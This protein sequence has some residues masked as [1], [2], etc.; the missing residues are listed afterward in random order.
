MFSIICIFAF[1]SNH[2]LAAT[3]QSEYSSA[4]AELLI[5]S[6]KDTS[7]QKRGEG[8]RIVLARIK[9]GEI[10]ISELSPKKVL[11]GPNGK[12]TIL[13]STVEEA[14][15]AI[16]C[17]KAKENVIYAEMDSPVY[18]CETHL[19]DT[20]EYSFHSWAAE[21][22]GYPL[23][24]DMANVEASGSIL[25]AIIDSGVAE[26]RLLRPRLSK[27]GFDYVDN[28]L[29]PT[30]DGSGHG[31]HVAGIVVDC[32]PSLEVNLMPI[33]VLNDNG[34]GRIANAVNA[35]D[36]AVEAGCGIINLSLVSQ[37]VS[38]ALDDA[39]NRAVENGVI[40]VVSAGN[41]GDDV[42]NYSPCHLQTEGLI[43]VGAVEADGTVASYSNYGSSVDV[44]AYGS[45]ISSCAVSGAYISQ[46][47]TSAAAPHITAACSIICLMNRASDPASCE[48]VLT[49]ISPDSV[50][51][52]P[53]LSNLVPTEV[54]IT[55][56]RVILRVGDIINLQSRA[57]PETCMLDLQWSSSN[58]QVVSVENNLLEALSEGEAIITV[59]FSKREIT[60]NVSVYESNHLG[61]FML[62]KGIT[63]LEDEA[64]MGVQGMELV[65][66]ND[67]ALIIGNYV[68]YE[69]DNLQ[70]VFLPET[71]TEIGD[72]PFETATLIVPKNS[73]AYSWAVINEQPYIIDTGQQQLVQQ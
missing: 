51:P 20:S 66:I 29:D 64:F 2:V 42:S 72:S 59:H 33:R 22:M 41:N 37:N 31:T 16:A 40:V 21:K 9:T 4:V 12:Y 13:F 24:L 18:S 30:N 5:D 19:Y 65:Q 10:D 23:F 43:V 71:V 6:E 17:L 62:P 46:S 73:Y 32:T 52:V 35:I 27:L 25:V 8:S 63:N 55:A 39:V 70:T 1:L 3:P 56:K 36:E 49:Q 15:D 28:D 61:S 48:A 47:G 34:G 38:D 26:H 54:G 14:R 57:A 50:R 45:N 68:F 69:C 67:G 7:L 60:C 11:S 58:D 53:L 44:F